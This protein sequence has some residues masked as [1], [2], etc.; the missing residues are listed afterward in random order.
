MSIVLSDRVNNNLASQTISSYD[1][2]ASLNHGGLLIAPAKLTEFFITEDLHTGL[3]YGVRD[4]LRREVV[5]WQQG[6]DTSNRSPQLSAL[7]DVV[8]EDFWD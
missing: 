4:R 8:L 5:K 7:L 6:G 1:W 3:R 2:W